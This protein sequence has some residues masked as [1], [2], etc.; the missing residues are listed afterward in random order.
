MPM[1]RCG[2]S[3]NGRD[4]DGN[5][6]CVICHGIH[7]GAEEVDDSPPDLSARRARCN[8]Y[9]TRPSGRNSESNYGTKR[10]EICMAERPSSPE[11]PFFMHRPD[12]EYDEFYCGCW[13][14]D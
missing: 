4:G 12:R 1:M 11:L 9:G 10:G 14:W 8:Y 5:P 6:V 13:G 3:D 2:H 7:P